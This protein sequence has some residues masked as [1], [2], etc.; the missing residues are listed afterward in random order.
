MH[1]SFY[2]YKSRHFT[3]F[4]KAAEPKYSKI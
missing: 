4:E 1:T 3:A 2:D